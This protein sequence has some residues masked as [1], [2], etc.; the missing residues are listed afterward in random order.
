MTE[1]TPYCHRVR[2]GVTGAPAI[3]G[4]DMDGSHAPGVGLAP[5]LIELVYSAARDGKPASVSA[6]VTGD[7]T[8]FG[9][10]DPDGFGG[11]VTTHFKSGPDGWPTWLMEEARLHDP[12]PNLQ[13]LR[14]QHTASLRH[15]DEVNNA[16]MEEVKR[17]ADGIEHPVL[18]SVYNAMHNR[19]LTAEAEAQRL[20]AGQTDLAQLEA[21]ARRALNALSTLILNH[22][23]PG[24][25]AHAAQYELRQTLSGKTP[26][27]PTLRVWQIEAQRRDGTWTRY[28]APNVDGADTHADFAE[29]IASSG[30]TR[31]FR[32]VSAVT[33]H[34]VDAL[35]TPSVEEANGA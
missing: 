28:S 7:W 16:L 11:Q 34:S 5:R 26:E 17:Y 14:D 8:R 13:D 4:A 27:I 9:Q 1:R 23:D 33:T 24:T 12:A 32:L 22:P 18:W 20:A 2:Y 30:K 15:A 19:A 25:E 21:A 6:S 10:R 29:T 35:H 3:D 31:P